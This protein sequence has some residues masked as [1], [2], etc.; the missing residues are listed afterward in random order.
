[1]VLPRQ[2]PVLFT[3]L[4]SWSN[5][6]ITPESGT[7]NDISLFSLVDGKEKAISVWAAYD[8]NAQ[9]FRPSVPSVNPEAIK[10]SGDLLEVT[11]LASVCL[12]SINSD[13]GVGK[14][15]LLPKFLSCIFYFMQP[16]DLHYPSVEARRVVIDRELRQYSKSHKFADVRVFCCSSADSPYPIEWRQFNNL[17]HGKLK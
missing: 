13:N 2:E 4:L 9:A 8:L 11:S 17:F 5:S 15:V 16:E 7:S 3:V 10:L 6:S 12:A 1:M 14:G